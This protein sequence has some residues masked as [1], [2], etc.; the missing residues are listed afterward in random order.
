MDLILWRHA[1]AEDG[2]P[3]LERRLTRRGHR[4]ALRMARWLDQQ[5]PASYR[6]LSSPA[7]RA[8]QTAAALS[9]TMHVDERLEPGARAQ[10]VLEASGWRKGG[11]TVVVVGHQPTLGQVAAFL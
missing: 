2:T 5:L 7:A 3:D 4:Q 10:A 11:R 8:R 1:E 9:P 6:I